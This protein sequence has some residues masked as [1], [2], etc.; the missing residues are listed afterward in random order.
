MMKTLNLKKKVKGFAVS[1]ELIFLSTIVTAGLAVGMVNV[2]DA[3]VGEMT[4]VSNAIGSLN[5]SFAFD[6]IINSQKTIEVAGSIF[7]DSVDTNAGDNTA[8]NFIAPNA[9]EV[10]GD[11]ASSTNTAVVG[12]GTQAPA[13]L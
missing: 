12:A 11:V 8:W 1:S 2:R 5:Q 6:G 3:V 9:L 10:G 7:G 13:P 4:D